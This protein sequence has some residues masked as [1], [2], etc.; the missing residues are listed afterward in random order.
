MQQIF[1][2]FEQGYLIMK[3]YKNEKYTYFYYYDENGCICQ[4][5]I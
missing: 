2:N 1:D 4:A 5:C 3:K